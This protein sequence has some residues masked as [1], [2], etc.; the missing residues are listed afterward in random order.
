MSI[1]I[2]ILLMVFAFLSG[3]GFSGTLSFIIIYRALHK[4][5]KSI[6]IEG[7]E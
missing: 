7:V 4:L 6:F 2:V 1:Y 3:I 5:A